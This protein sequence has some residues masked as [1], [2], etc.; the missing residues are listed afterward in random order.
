MQTDYDYEQMKQKIKEE[1][2]KVENF[3][4]VEDLPNNSVQEA[5]DVEKEKQEIEKENVEDTDKVEEHLS[6]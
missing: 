6:S 5:Q 4:V 1:Q 2:N 3:E